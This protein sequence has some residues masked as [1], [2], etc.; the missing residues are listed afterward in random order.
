MDNTILLWINQGWAH[1]WLDPFFIWVSQR[2]S[3]SFPLLVIILILCVRYFKRDGLK[4]WL[5]LLALLICGDQL[6]NV[7]KYLTAQPRP[8]YELHNIV[9]Q[10][11]RALPGPCGSNLD[12]MPSNHALNFFAIAIF[13]MLVVRIRSWGI[14]MCI[15][16]LLVGISRIYLGK[17]YPSQVLAGAVIGSLL[18]YLAA[19]LGIKYLAFIQRVHAYRQPVSNSGSAS[20]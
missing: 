5:L 7:I 12:A 4:L 8:C 14:I 18:G 20:R 19:W 2:A 15:I 10:P 16:A 1:S 9:R 13:I 3:F 11:A 6:G 17:H